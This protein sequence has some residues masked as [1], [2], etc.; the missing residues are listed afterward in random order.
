M[1]PRRSLAVCLLFLAACAV[2][3]EVDTG[4]VDS[5]RRTGTGGAQSGGASGTGGAGASG[6]TGG[7]TGGSGGSATGGTG[8]GATGGSGGGAT[9]GT[10]GTGGSAT[11]GTGG[12][13]TGG[14]GGSGG[15]ARDGATDSTGTGGTAPT[16]GTGGTSGTGGSGGSTTDASTAGLHV[17]YAA[18]KTQPSSPYVQCEIHV[19]NNGSVPVQVSELKLRYYFTDEVKKPPQIMINWSHVCAPGNCGH[20]LTVT[21][22]AMPNVPPASSADTYIE[23]GFSSGRTSLGSGDSAD[24]TFQMQGPNPATDVYMQTNDYSFDASKTAVS[25][26]PN[27]VLLQ[28]GNVAWGTPP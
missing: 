4:K 20:T 16:G 7:V 19:K 22:A 18:L 2:G 6:G 12:V 14:S 21:S 23:F 28:N 15:V 5:G 25:A 26:W 3:E 8:T 9:G 24:F 10:G 11:G 1:T 13:T 27:I 17:L